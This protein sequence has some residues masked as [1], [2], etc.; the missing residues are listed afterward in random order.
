MTERLF[1]AALLDEAAFDALD[2]LPTRA[3]RGVR[4]TKRI[5]WHIT[6]RFLGECEVG[7]A[8]AALAGVEADSTTA[9]LGPEVALLGERVVMVPVDGVNPLAESVAKA[10]E[11]VGEDQGDRPFLAHLTLARLKGH[12]LRHPE[13]ISVLGHPIDVSWP[14]DEIVLVKSELTPDGAEHSVVAT[15]RLG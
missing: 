6:L 11:G 15:R 7:D 2:Q 13:S 4:W 8:I 1:V 10:F 14:V 3:Q 9:R 12:P 5:T